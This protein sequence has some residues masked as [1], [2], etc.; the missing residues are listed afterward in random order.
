MDNTNYSL[1]EQAKAKDITLTPVQQS[2]IGELKVLLTYQDQFQSINSPI[3]ETIE[4]SMDIAAVLQSVENKNKEHIFLREKIEN[5]TKENENLRQQLKKY[6]S[7]VQMLNIDNRSAHK[8]LAHLNMTVEDKNTVEPDYLYE[9][10][11]YENKLI[12]VI[13]SF[14]FLR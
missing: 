2:E 10:K 8:A 1:L 5:L 11:F 7:A 12:Q 13:H 4:I 6:V 9:A 14:L 3:D